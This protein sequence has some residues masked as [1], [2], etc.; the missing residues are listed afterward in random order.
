MLRRFKNL[1]GAYQVLNLDLSG[2]NGI[3]T[4]NK[5]RVTIVTGYEGVGKSTFVLHLFE[6]WFKL[7]N[8]PLTHDLITYFGD[9]QKTFISALN[10]AP[11]Y[12]MVVHDEAGKDLYTRN[13]MST[14]TKDLNVAYQVIRGANL[15][16]I[17]IIPHILDLD[18]FFRRRRITQCF[19]VY[20]EGKVAYF[21]KK[22]L[23][24]LMPKITKMAQN[25]DDIDL[26]SVGQ[27][28]FLDTFGKYEG[29][30]LKD[31][32]ERKKNN[33]NETK[34]YLYDKY[35]AEVENPQIIQKNDDKEL[36]FS[37]I[38]QSYAKIKPLI[39]K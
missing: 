34:Q 5:D 4:K 24:Q 33:I 23:R 39:Y 16:T 7:L 14:F 29:I 8:I 38:S 2:K 18:S 30:F 27:P 21:T 36:N 32:L 12:Y 15:H 9:N 19:H 37:N 11:Q 3:K 13:A 17:L 25:S 26:L 1:K 28:L 31:Y 6:H 22:R 35:V 20:G 10:T